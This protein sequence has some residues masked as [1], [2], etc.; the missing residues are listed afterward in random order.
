MLRSAF[1]ASL[2]GLGSQFADWGDV[3]V[4]TAGRTMLVIRNVRQ[5]SMS[6]ID[7]NDALIDRENDSCIEL[8]FSIRQV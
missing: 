4:Y 2:F 1:C 5:Q 6:F 7:R 3:V 8:W